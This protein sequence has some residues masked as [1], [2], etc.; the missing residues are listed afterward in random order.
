MYKTACAAQS[1]AMPPPDGNA[2]RTVAG[3]AAGTA[4][5]SGWSEPRRRLVDSRA[6]LYSYEGICT[7]GVLFCGP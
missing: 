6:Q 5:G 3:T 1:P 2:A 4:A 7:F